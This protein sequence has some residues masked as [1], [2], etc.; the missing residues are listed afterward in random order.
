MGFLPTYIRNMPAGTGSQGYAPLV[1][2]SSGVDNCP[3]SRGKIIHDL[4]PILVPVGPMS[5]DSFLAG[6][7]S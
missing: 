1:V 2:W 3:S 5:C 6:S 7:L 4:S